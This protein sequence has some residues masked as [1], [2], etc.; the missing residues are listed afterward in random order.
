MTPTEQKLVNAVNWFLAEM[1][2]FS[3]THIRKDYMNEWYNE[4]LDEVNNCLDQIKSI[5]VSKTEIKLCVSH[6]KYVNKAEVSRSLGKLDTVA[7]W[8]YAMGN[9]TLEA[10]GHLLKIT[11]EFD[12]FMQ[13]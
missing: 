13:A 9:V 11:S 4:K 7:R 5:E 2:E 10:Q 6:Q 3:A 8:L 1:R 12:K